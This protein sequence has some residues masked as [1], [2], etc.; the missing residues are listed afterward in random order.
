MLLGTWGEGTPKSIYAQETTGTEPQ[1]DPK[2]SPQ[3]TLRTL[4]ALPPSRP[5]MMEFREIGHP[6][7]REGIFWSLTCLLF[8]L[9]YCNATSPKAHR[10]HYLVV[11]GVSALPFLPSQPQPHLCHGEC[12]IRMHDVCGPCGLLLAPG[13]QRLSLTTGT[14]CFGLHLMS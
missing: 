2:G 4:W 14:I 12:A 6:A 11:C 10:G 13:T 1:P 8:L 5:L 3:H 9:P 7:M